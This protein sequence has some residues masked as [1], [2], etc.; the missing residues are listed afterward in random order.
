MNYFPEANFNPRQYMQAQ[1]PT[2]N[3]PYQPV[4]THKN[5]IQGVRTVRT[6]DEVNGAQVG[7]GESV[8]F[9]FEDEPTFA[10]KTVSPSGVV[11][12]KL[13]D[14][15]ERQ[16]AP[17]AYVTREEFDKL[18]EQINVQSSIPTDPGTAAITAVNGFVRDHANDANISGNPG[19]SEGSVLPTSG[20]FGLDS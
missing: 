12:T 7:F 20:I 17:D 13:Y 16:Q 6:M 11:T 8:M 19:S 15:V 4:Q 5:Q 18:K 2:Y 14:F 9:M 1:W 3:Y 10:L